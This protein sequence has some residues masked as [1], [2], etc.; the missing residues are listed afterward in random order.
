MT[1]N[2]RFAADQG[3][4]ASALDIAAAYLPKR[5]AALVEGGLWCEPEEIDEIRL[6]RDRPASLTSRGKNIVTDLVCTP[7]E[8]AETIS[9]LCGGTMHAHS[10]TIAQGYIAFG[11]GGRAG[12]CGRAVGG[13]AGAPGGAAQGWAIAGVADIDALC[14][15]VPRSVW[16]IS[17]RLCDYLASRGYAASALVYSP[18]GGGKTT[19]LRDAASA[20]ARAPHSRRV[21]VIDTRGELYREDMFRGAIADIFTGYPK[22]AGIELATRT[23]SPQY[24]VC[25]EIGAPDEAAA[26]LAAQHTGVPLLA[27]AHAATYDELIARPA[28]RILLD[29]GIFERCL[30]VAEVCGLW[31]R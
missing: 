20:L 6:R 22:A 25:D 10:E 29:A 12:V 7:P 28:V 13:Q 15:R 14:I 9:R 11:G 24:L 2:K 26:I 21:A 5:L 27:S 31:M 3:K 1:E 19:L 16:G 8:L 17:A 4:G 30:S 23:M 18:P